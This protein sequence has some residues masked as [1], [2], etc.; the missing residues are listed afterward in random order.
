MNVR[1]SKWCRVG[2]ARA[3]AKIAGMCQATRARAA[4]NQQTMGFARNLPN[5]WIGD[6]RDA[7]RR[8]LST[9]RWGKPRR[10]GAYGRAEQEQR[11]SDGHEQEVLE[12]VSGEEAFIEHAKR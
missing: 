7:G 11:R 8:M 12:H 9:K 3:E 6:I 4:A 10:S 1:C 5:R 2:D